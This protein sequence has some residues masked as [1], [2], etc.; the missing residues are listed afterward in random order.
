MAKAKIATDWLM[1]CS[2]CEI[3]LLDIH[4]GIVDVLGKADIVRSPVLT[5]VKEF[6]PADV[7]ILSGGIRNE[8]NIHVAKEM[9][10]NCKTIIALGSCA[11][12][13]GVPSLANISSRKDF[14]E[15]VYLKTIGVDNPLGREPQDDLPPI[16]TDVVPLS[17]VI[18]V[19]VALPGCPPISETIAKVL[20]SLLDGTPLELPST[21]VCDPCPRKKQ[22]TKILDLKR[23]YRSACESVDPEQCFLEQGYLCLGP[24]SLGLCEARCTY[25]GVPCRGCTGP[26]NPDRDSGLDA[27]SF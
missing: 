24:V 13:G 1:A 3:S 18:E 25:V 27:A 9:R 12:F 8:H 22:N 23:W 4:E 10:K 16:T 17:S 5:D 2:G 21:S 20:T 7:G 11:C 26:L 6:A 14:Y 15:K 19:D